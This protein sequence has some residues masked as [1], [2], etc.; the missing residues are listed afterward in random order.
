MEGKSW[1]RLEPDQRGWGFDLI[2]NNNKE[3]TPSRAPCR[4]YQTSPFITRN[5]APNPQLTYLDRVVMEIIE[6]ERMY[7]RDLRMIVEVGHVIIEVSHMIFEAGGINKPQIVHENI[8]ILQ[9]E[10]PESHISG[11][12][13]RIIIHPGRVASSSQCTHN[14][15]LFI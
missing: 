2:H 1:P 9:N 10:K 11:L 6:T 3:A 12:Q 7:V 14:S 5:M 15:V 13:Q 4:R 8:L